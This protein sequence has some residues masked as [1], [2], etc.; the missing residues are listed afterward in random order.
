MKK[1]GCHDN[2]CAC[3][4]GLLWQPT[5]MEKKMVVL[6]TQNVYKMGYKEPC[7]RGLLWQPLC[8]SMW[9]A[10][11]AM[12]ACICKWWW[13]LWICMNMGCYDQK[14]ASVRYRC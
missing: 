14:K 11:A 4:Y 1:I 9:V 8:V 7:P 3:K 13:Q 5:C 10:M 2:P 12:N 6:A